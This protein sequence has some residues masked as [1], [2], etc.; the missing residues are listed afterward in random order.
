M[1]LSNALRRIYFG[2]QDFLV[3]QVRTILVLGFDAL[4]QTGNLLTFNR[5]FGYVIAEGKPGRGGLWPPFEAPTKADSRSPCPALNAMAN[6]GIL[7]RD[8]RGIPIAGL[9]PA[10]C[11]TYNFSSSFAYFTLNYMAE[12]LQKSY[13]YDTFDLSDLL[14]HNGIE[15]DASLTRYD[16]SR[17]PDQA[18][19]AQDLVDQL[20]ASATGR[21]KQGNAMLTFA[22]L[23]RFSTER[24]DHSRATNGQYTLSTFHKLF[25]SSNTTT[26]I[27][28]Y[29][30]RVD[31]LAVILK[32]ERIP[33]GWEPRIRSR[34]GLTIMG[35]NATV[36]PLEFGIKE[37]RGPRTVRLT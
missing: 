22:D 21:D 11:D 4:L 12:M 2:L 24:R 16:V 8:G 26:L 6:H 1:F 31:D 13:A 25:G 29:G 32:E 23:T 36:L 15:H 3:G 19:P 28:I 14:V 30:G 20:L 33:D 34:N 9:G 7:P 18:V 17:Q 35:M 5:R 10:L 37:R 27:T